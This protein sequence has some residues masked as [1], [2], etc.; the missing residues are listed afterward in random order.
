MNIKYQ[1]IHSSSNS[2]ST[3]DHTEKNKSL[4]RIR[5]SSY[6]SHARCDECVKLQEAR[7]S[8]KS[9]DDL[10]MVRKSTEKHRQEYA[11]ARIEINRLI[12]QSQSFPKDYLGQLFKNTVFNFPVKK[13]RQ[14]EC[15]MLA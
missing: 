15:I 10:D 6:S 3:L 12:Q 7:K 1:K 13:L 9:M 5:I 11:G 4:P 2:K 8:I 14:I